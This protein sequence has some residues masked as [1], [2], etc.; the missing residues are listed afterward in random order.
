VGQKLCFV[1]AHGLML[2]ICWLMGRGAW[3]QTIINLET[4]SAVMQLPMAWLYASGVVFAVLAGAF[5]L[6]E[7]VRLFTGR[8]RDDELIGVVESDDMPHGNPSARS[9]KGQP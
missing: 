9:D 5:I 8:L 4:T 3:Q 7:L 6:I 2:Y 1:A